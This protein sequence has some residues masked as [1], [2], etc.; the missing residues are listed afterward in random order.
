MNNY[1]GALN[2]FV[3]ESQPGSGWNVRP[4]RVGKGQ[5]GITSTWHL[6]DG[7]Y[8][9]VK[10]II[11]GYTLPPEKIRKYY[12]SNLRIYVSVQNP[13][14]FTKYQGYNPEVSNRNT[15]TSSGEDYGVYPTAKTTSIGVNISF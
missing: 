8:L 10:N 5:N 15:V 2:H 14:L 6:E 4:N 13:F 3:S 1:E 9:R 11:L 12:M 7:S